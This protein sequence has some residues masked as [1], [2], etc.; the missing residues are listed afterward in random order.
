MR[1]YL[2]FIS[3]SLSVVGTVHNKNNNHANNNNKCIDLAISMSLRA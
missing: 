1:L 3:S 2:W